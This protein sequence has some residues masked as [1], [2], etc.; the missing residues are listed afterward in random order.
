MDMKLDEFDWFCKRGAVAAGQDT[1]VQRPII[2]DGMVAVDSGI[3]ATWYDLENDDRE[4]FVAWLHDIYLPALAKNQSFLWIAHFQRYQG[5]DLVRPWMR[6]GEKRPPR[7]SADIGTGAS[8][9]VLVGA[10]SSLTFFNPAILDS[11]GDGI[12][13]AKEML[14][15]RRG[16]RHEIFTEE[17]R[18]L[19]PAARSERLTMGPAPAIQF[20][21]FRMVD[22]DDALA[23]RWFSQV[24][25]P[26]METTSASLR[27]RKWVGA[28]GWA[29]HGVLYEF[30]SID[31]RNRAFQ[32]N[33]DRRESEPDKIW[34]IGPYTIHAPGSS[35]AGQRTYLWER[36]GH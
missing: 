2:S 29:K 27:T 14:A 33:Q 15:R 8:Y 30:G 26:A 18:V 17:A 19:G 35:F 16:V 10:V 23:G 7:T 9:V 4:G 3:W 34:P 11:E 25:F 31:M 13:G 5:T 20:G 24:C 32:E 28:V 6:E 12:P 21:S 22:D 36:Q 1:H